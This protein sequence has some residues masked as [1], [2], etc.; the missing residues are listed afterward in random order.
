MTSISSDTLKLSP[1]RK[2]SKTRLARMALSGTGNVG[3]GHL[4][5]QY[6]LHAAQLH[7]MTSHD[8]EGVARPE[9]GCEKRETIDMIP[10]GMGQK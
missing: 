2:S 1:A 4:S 3:V 5:F 6:I 8:Q 9:G 7:Q 10:M